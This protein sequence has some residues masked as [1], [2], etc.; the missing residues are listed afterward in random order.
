MYFPRVYDVISE[1][2]TNAETVSRGNA[3]DVILIV[4][5]DAS[6]RNVTISMVRELG[7]S[8]IHAPNASEALVEIKSNPAITLLFTDIVMPD[9][10]GRQL[11]DQAK[12]LNPSLRVLYTTGY[13][14]NAIVHNG[15]LDAGVQLLPKPFTLEALSHKLRDV[16]DKLA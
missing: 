2:K 3:S 5:D 16:L 7:Y 9:I 10:N 12:L 1:S 4:E 14:R 6:V 15:I 11:A 8:V 13:S